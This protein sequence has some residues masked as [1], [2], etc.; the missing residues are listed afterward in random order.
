MEHNKFFLQNRHLKLSN[1]FFI[2]WLG[3]ADLNTEGLA[4][5]YSADGKL[6]L[7]ESRQNG[8]HQFSTATNRGPTQLT[9]IP[10]VANYIRRVITLADRFGSISEYLRSFSDA[11]CLAIYPGFGTDASKTDENEALLRVFYNNL[12][13]LRPGEAGAFLAR[14]VFDIANSSG[15]ARQYVRHCLM[16]MSSQFIGIICGHGLVSCNLWGTRQQHALIEGWRYQLKN[17]KKIYTNL[18]P[19]P[20]GRASISLI[21][22]D[23]RHDDKLA[24]LAATGLSKSDLE[25]AV[26]LATLATD[27]NDGQYTEALLYCLGAR[28]NLGISREEAPDISS[29]GD[30]ID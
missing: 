30:L 26:D 14:S 4:W 18:P 20:G 2:T 21:E 15:Q 6:F 23:L 12:E 7:L 10:D 11:V 28:S 16:H 17:P 13:H 8:S 5:H 27:V 25:D 22:R 24:L 29:L 3:P 19:H 9:S 1:E